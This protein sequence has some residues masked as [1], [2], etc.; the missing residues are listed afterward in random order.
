[1]GIFFLIGMFLL[2]KFLLFFLISFSSSAS[3][4][5]RFCSANCAK[6]ST[7]YPSL[8]NW[9]GATIDAELVFWEWVGEFSGGVRGLILV[10]FSSSIWFLLVR[11]VSID[12]LFLGFVKLARCMMLRLLGWKLAVRYWMVCEGYAT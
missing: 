10:R 2:M 12:L 5:M 1:M 7:L 3:C 4:S 9:D 11:S 6:T 8:L